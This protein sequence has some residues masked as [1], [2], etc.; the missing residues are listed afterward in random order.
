[1]VALLV[2]AAASAAAA[3]PE[4]T[5]VGDRPG[6]VV[7]VIGDGT[8][9]QQWGLFLSARRAAGRTEPSNFE[10]LAAA[11]RVGTM[12]T[13]AADSLVTDSAA[14]ATAL[15]SARRTANGMVGVGPGGESLPTCLEKGSARGLWSGLVTTTCVADATP[16]A[17]AAHVKSRRQMDEAAAQLLRGHDLRVLLGG[18]TPYF[19]PKGKPMS[20]AGPPGAGIPDAPSTRRDDEDLVAEARAKGFAVATTREALLAGPAP[21]RLLGLFAPFDFPYAIDRDGKEEAVAPTLAEMTG[22][23]LEVL[24]RAPKG[25]FLM[26]EA[27]LVDHACHE[28]DAGAVLGEMEE[29]DAALGVLLRERER[30]PDLLVVLTADHET[31]G[32]SVGMPGRALT[33]GTLARLATQ[34]RSLRALAAGR[35][36]G[37]VPSEDEARAAVPWLPAKAAATTV[38]AV[39]GRGAFLGR[40]R[41]PYGDAASGG[42]GV[43]FATDGHT[44]TPVPLVAQGP[45][46][47]RFAGVLDNVAV[48]EVLMDLLGSE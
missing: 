42:A 6:S 12:T 40:S 15:A 3:L 26:V 1:M 27:G 22:R 37:E 18:G 5:R 32:L 43:V 7:L 35:R 17:F 28:N 45:G 20:A 25:Y 21:E 23:A 48:G 34:R 9:W 10:R 39:D 41:L 29:L 8:G 2:V 33:P 19:V 44:A 46:A 31:G 14:G 47:A 38:P 24:R 16:A 36:P 4:G 13:W 30:R 11:G